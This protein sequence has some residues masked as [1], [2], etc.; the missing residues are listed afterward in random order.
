MSRII[1]YITC[2]YVLT[3][4]LL[5]AQNSKTLKGVIQDSEKNPL[6]GITIYLKETNQT[7]YSNKKGGFKSD[8]LPKD[9]KVNLVIK[10]NKWLLRDSCIQISPSQQEIIIT[11]G[12]QEKTLK[13]I[14]I[15]GN[16]RETGKDDSP[17]NT[18]IITPK[19]LQKTGSVN[20]LE[21]ASFVNG[22]RPQINCNVCSTGDIHINGQEGPY[23]LVLIDGMPIISGLS[24]VYG[25]SGIPVGMI[26]QVEVIKG[27]ASSIYGS[28]AM[29]GVINIITKKATLSPKFS[30]DYFGTNYQE[31]NL[32]SGMRFNLKNS[33]HI[34]GISSFWYNKPYDINNDGFTDIALQKRISIFHKIDNEQKN[35]KKVSIAGRYLY[36]DRWGGQMNWERKFKGS[37]SIYGESIE[38]KRI[39]IISNYQWPIK[40]NITTQISYNR[41]FQNSFYGTNQLTAE[42]NVGF[43]QTFWDKKINSRHQ[44]VVGITS[45]YQY[46]DDNTIVTQTDSLNNRPE[47][48]LLVGS[49]IQVEKTLDKNSKHLILFGARTDFHPI[50]KFI[51]SP[52]LAYKWTPNYRNIFRLNAGTGFRIVQVFTEDHA[53]LT[54]SREVIFAEK[55]KPEQSLCF[56]GNYLYKMPLLEKNILNIDVSLFYYYFFNKIVAN[57]DENPNKI[58]YRNLDGNGTTKGGSLNVKLISS[59]AVSVNAGITYADVINTIV[60]SS[61]NTLKTQQLNSPK[62]SGN[63]VASYNITKL[64]TRIDINGIFN[65]PQRLAILP[66]DFRPE[67]SPWYCLLN[68]QIVKKIR[69]LGEFYT[70]VKNLLNFIPQHPIMRPFDPFD[71]N[72]N[73]SISN[74]HGYT[75]DTSYNY[76]PIQGIRFF[77]GLRISIQ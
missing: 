25:L 5:H 66:N 34:S 29:G 9:S 35:G 77:A 33:R 50:H 31:H 53:A 14:V 18:D 61:G 32:E 2:W 20:L 45:K 70:G 44:A 8:S 41:H 12:S 57:Y 6:P 65:G 48:N 21:A 56:N 4:P 76:A 60:D 54:G 37:D 72:I 68:L 67:Y 15:T 28:E 38:T 59:G 62:W 74:P 58:I 19:F 39:E 17:V 22:V 7:I 26:E 55:L 63:F 40:E 3:I 71:K 64:T 16:L 43:F 51:P 49:F 75:F 23:T 27:P 69:I 47:I 46:Y 13:E 30:F 36:E 24:S 52:R 73:D 42:Q 1:L 11:L 10:Q